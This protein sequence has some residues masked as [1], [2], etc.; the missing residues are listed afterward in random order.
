[1]RSKR[2]GESNASLGIKPSVEGGLN[3]ELIRS[4]GGVK[5]LRLEGTGPHLPT[6]D[7]G[8]EMKRK[9]N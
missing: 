3:E 6:P 8:Y 4:L 2:E 1:M 7:L 9:R 5:L